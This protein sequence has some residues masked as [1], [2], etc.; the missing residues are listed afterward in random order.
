VQARARPPA[1]RLY[2]GCMLSHGDSPPRAPHCE[3]EAAAEEHQA[4]WWPHRVVPKRRGPH[5][6]VRGDAS[7]QRAHACSDDTLSGALRGGNLFVLLTLALT[8]TLVIVEEAKHMPAE[9]LG[10][11]C[12]FARVRQVV[13]PLHPFLE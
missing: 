10:R 7:I 2:N 5:T 12:N 9:R 3:T 6:H 1:Q 4:P 8:F 13:H 11:S